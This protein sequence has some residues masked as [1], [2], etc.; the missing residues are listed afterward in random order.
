[1]NHSDLDE[2]CANLAKTA[3]AAQR[4]HAEAAQ[5]VNSSESADSSTKSTNYDAK[6]SAN[7]KPGRA[8]SLPE[9]EW[10]NVIAPPVPTNAMF[11]GLLGRFAHCAAL[12]TEVNPAAAMAGA[13]T[14]LTAAMGRNI[15][16]FIGNSWHGIRINTVH[17]GRTSCGRKG[18]ALGLLKRMVKFMETNADCAK[19]LPRKHE[20]GLSSREGLA[21]LIHDSYRNGKEEIE[22]IEDKRLF[23]LEEEFANVLAQ[24]KRDGNT[25]SASIRGVFDSVSI[26]PAAKTGVWATNPHIAIHGCI[27]PT[28]LRAKIDSCQ[29]SWRFLRDGRC[30]LSQAI[31]FIFCGFKSTRS[32]RCQFRVAPDQRFGFLAFAA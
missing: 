27:T 20:G 8:N 9:R 16:L 14:W 19:L 12:G 4:N 5:P 11:Y 17:V 15:G 25:L 6:S 26:Q 10:D 13:M 22:G 30:F 2:R 1:M 3:A 31:S 21:M 18:D 7:S 29:A 32:T 23:V 24:C 28:E